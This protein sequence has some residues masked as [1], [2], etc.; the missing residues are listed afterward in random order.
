MYMSHNCLKEAGT[1]TVNMK[2]YNRYKNPEGIVYWCTI[3]GRICLGHRHYEL[4][5]PNQTLQLIPVPPGQD[6]FAKDCK[7]E[8]GGGRKEKMMRFHAFRQLA[9]LLQKKIGK[10]SH[11]E[12]MEKLLT[13]MWL[14]PMNPSTIELAEE[15]LESKQFAISANLFPKPVVKNIANIPRNAR[16]TELIPTVAPGYNAISTDHDEHAIQ[17]HHR[18]ADGTINRHEGPLGK[19]GAESFVSYIQSNL[20]DGKAGPCWQPSCTAKIHPEEIRVLVDLG[21]FPKDLYSRYKE[22]FNTVQR[23]GRGPLIQ[24]AALAECVIWKNR[25]SSNRKNRTTRKRMRSKRTSL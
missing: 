15:N 5:G 10:L 14:G 1:S 19:I 25:Q 7:G 20:S 11:E 23:G 3:C 24:E 2:L 18:M 8:G 21:V 16:N 12:A 9:A 4:G 6:P 13:A 22:A 17:F